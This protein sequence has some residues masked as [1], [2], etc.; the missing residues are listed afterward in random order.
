MF[1]IYRFT[2]FTTDFI[3]FVNQFK[4]SPK[5]RKIHDFLKEIIK[6]IYIFSFDKNFKTILMIKILI[7]IIHVTF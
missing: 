2:G 5:S 6:K 4:T 7:K 1:Y 3:W